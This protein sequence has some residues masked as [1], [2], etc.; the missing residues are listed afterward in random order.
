LENKNDSFNSALALHIFENSTHL[1]LF[2]EA[3]LISTVNGLL[4]SFKD[5]IEIKKIYKHK[6]GNK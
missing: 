6:F 5:I 3:N 2:E 1:V 4:L